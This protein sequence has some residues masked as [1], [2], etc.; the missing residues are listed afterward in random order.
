[1]PVETRTF[2][3]FV[4][5][6]FDDLKDERDAL[7]REVFPRLRELCRR[8]GARFQAID[9]RW[10]VRTEAA[11][12][13]RTMEICISEIERCRHTGFRPNFFVL[14]GDRYGWRP[15]PAR[16]PEEE[17]NQ[18]VG[19]MAASWY[20]LDQNAVPEEY[21]LK[22]RT[23]EFPEAELHEELLQRA[24]R[25]GLPR[26]VLLRYEASAVHQ[27][28]LRGLGTA[29][30]DREHVFAFCRR[31]RRR[32][33]QEP[34]LATLK[35]LLPDITYFDPGALPKLCSDVYARLERVIL[36][37]LSRLAS[38][39]PLVVEIE[40]HD[41]FG[42]EKARDFVGRADALRTIREYL[43]GGDRR[44]FVLHGPSGSGKSA[45]MAHA[46]HHTDAIRRFIGATPE[47]GNAVALLTG[48][49][50]QMGMSHPGPHLPDVA[51][52]FQQCLTH[53][54]REH[55]L[56]LF[57]DGIDQLEDVTWLPSRL[58][59]HCRLVI[60]AARP[61]PGC[62][63]FELSAMSTEEAGDLLDRWLKAARR[64]L[65]DGQRREVMRAFA[66]SGLPLHLKLAFEEA[67]RWRSFDPP[68][69]G[70]G[71]EGILDVMTAR[72]SEHRNHGPVLTERGLGY[73][74][75]A[76]DG[77]TEDEMVDLLSKDDPVWYD[78]VVR[79]HH[80][81]PSR[82]LPVIVW[83][84][85]LI[86]IEPYLVEIAAPGGAVVTWQHRRL[87][88]WFAARYDRDEAAFQPHRV[89]AGHFGEE[90]TEPL[91]LPGTTQGGRLPNYRKLRELP[92]QQTL[93]P[94]HEELAAT[95][96]NL[97]FLEAKSFAEMEYDLLTD[98]ERAAALL[99]SAG[100]LQ[101]AL[102][103]A[104]QPLRARPD[105]ILQTLYNRLVWIVNDFPALRPSLEQARE[106]L[107]RRGP[108]LELQ[109]KPAH[110]PSAGSVSYRMPFGSAV[111][112]VL[113][114]ADLLAFARYDGRLSAHRLSTGQE[115]FTRS[116]AAGNVAR[117]L[118]LGCRSDRGVCRPQRHYRR[119]AG[120]RDAP[121]PPGRLS[122][123]LRRP[124]G[125][126]GSPGS[127]ARRLASRGRL[128]RGPRYSR[129]GTSR[130]PSAFW[131]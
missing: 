69:L 96:G 50:R 85:L 57:L 100:F 107:D 88:E 29:P 116:L 6:T 44:V 82:N 39:P 12:D 121:W 5:S 86:D 111:Q 36:A 10:G 108:W 35:K 18:V 13:H 47:S 55:P 34:G 128:L 129:P 123:V 51:A 58:P 19:P 109:S 75:A 130:R 17:F 8:H 119:R 68:H 21:L 11:A 42:R 127:C 122:S 46:S 72:L 33:P 83:L 92:Y 80:V 97:A 41:A 16:I 56:L 53:G 15:V 24:R 131:I 43:D 59:P 60:S 1:M 64:T 48:L 20:E 38:R 113:P 114:E 117:H 99:P 26:D 61:M 40:A 126:G 105:H 31:A 118:P 90:R 89:L 87:R 4:S 14:L 45:V 110:E 49:C 106:T 67:R 76:R 74:T 71:I 81:P 124:M 9:L 77:I 73:L 7:Q 125:S 37:E 79:A 25:A 115:L 84:R 22:P 103:R 104:V 63:S 65:N 70:E 28:I 66:A 52:A 2:R 78:F 102:S 94:M 98:C 27:E 112:A 3:L 93:A 23:S 30:A 101:A 32:I 91:W 95:L 62:A 120:Q 54:T